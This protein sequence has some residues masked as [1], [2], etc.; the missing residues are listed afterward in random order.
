VVDAGAGWNLARQLELRFNVRNLFDSAYYA[1]P[2]ARWVW[3][4]GR[5]AALTAVVD[6]D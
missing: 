1:S 4:P 3:A 6:F 2:D 5:S